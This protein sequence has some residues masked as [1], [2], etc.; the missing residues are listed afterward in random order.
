MR[1][2]AAVSKLKPSCGYFSFGGFIMAEE[3][4]DSLNPMR[5]PPWKNRLRGDRHRS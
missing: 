1:F 5:S 3:A 4:R 2:M